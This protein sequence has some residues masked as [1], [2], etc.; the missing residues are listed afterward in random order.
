[1]F[2]YL[3]SVRMSSKLLALGVFVII[4]LALM[5]T[6]FLKWASSKSEAEP[7]LKIGYCDASPEDLC[8]LSF[9]RDLKENMVINFFVPDRKFPD[10][11]LKIKRAGGESVY[12]CQKDKEVPT[13]VYC[14]GELIG[15]QEKIEIN[16]LSKEDDHL[17]AS[18]VL[19]LQAIL[20]S[21]TDG[22]GPQE[23]PA[24]AFDDKLT[25]TPIPIFTPTLTSTATLTPT[26]TLT[27]SYP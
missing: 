12:E 13:S 14:T 8:I 18:G 3:S 2:K 21:L 4:L 26:L 22:G 25:T 15:L 6:V 16:L 11:Y 24:S 19:T 23:P 1:M 7:I 10:F 27:P 5:G 9:S 17:M 20:L